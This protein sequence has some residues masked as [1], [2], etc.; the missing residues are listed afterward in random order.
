M[1]INEPR[2]VMASPTVILLDDIVEPLVQP[3]LNQDVTATTELLGGS[4]AP[5]LLHYHQP[6]GT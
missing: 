1:D 6:W 2:S 4:G 5:L 3:L